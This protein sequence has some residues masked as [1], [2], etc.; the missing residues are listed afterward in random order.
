MIK[1]GQMEYINSNQFMLFSL[2]KL[3][4]NLDVIKC[5]NTNCKYYHR[6]DKNQCIG[7][8]TNYKITK[9]YYKKGCY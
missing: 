3:A 6:I 5:K 1:V 7:T 9:Q 2:A 8:L 4:D